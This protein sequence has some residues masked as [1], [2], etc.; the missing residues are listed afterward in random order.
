MF[1]ENRLQTADDSHEI[2]STAD[3]PHEIPSLIFI[4]NQ[5]YFKMCRLLHFKDY[6]ER[7]RAE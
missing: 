4:N 1:H 2:P 5:R 3:D 7:K 6:Y